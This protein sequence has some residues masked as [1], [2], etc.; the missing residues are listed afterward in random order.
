[1]HLD[2]VNT[3]VILDYVGKNPI[4]RVTLEEVPEELK[5][6]PLSQSKLKSEKNILV[7]LVQKFGKKPALADTDTVFEKGD[8]ITMFGEYKTICDTF[9]AKENFSDPDTEE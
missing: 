4:A 1:M 3:M 8:K 7:I 9:D 5:D 2:A 6:V